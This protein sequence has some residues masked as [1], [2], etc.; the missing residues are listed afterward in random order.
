M[1]VQPNGPHWEGPCLITRS[2]RALQQEG[3]R[4]LWGLLTCESQTSETSQIANHWIL[5]WW[6]DWYCYL[7]IPIHLY[8]WKI[9][10]YFLVC[11]FGC[12]RSYLQHVG[13]SLCHGRFLFQGTAFLVV[14]RGLNCSEACGILIPQLGIESASPGWQGEFLTTGPPGK[15]LQFTFSKFFWSVSDHHWIPSC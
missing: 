7:L 6:A 4:G 15:S 14:V 11:L 12:T 3:W 8:F 1:D 13:S 2:E 9:F 5:D 10:I